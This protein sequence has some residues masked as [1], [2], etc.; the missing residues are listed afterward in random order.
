MIEGALAE[1][2]AKGIATG[3]QQKARAMAA[4]LLALGVEPSI[5]AKASGLSESDI[6]AMKKLK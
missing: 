4:E 3:Q 1:G 6:L 2:E 5:I